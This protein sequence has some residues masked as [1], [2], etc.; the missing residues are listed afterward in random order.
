MDVGLRVPLEGNPKVTEARAGITPRETVY[1]VQAGGQKPMDAIVG[2][3]SL[4]A[5]AHVVCSFLP[6][7]GILTAFL[8]NL[9]PVRRRLKQ[10]PA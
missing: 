5:Q 6:V 1:R 8:P 2:V 7:I 10:A 3:T 9:E 4:N